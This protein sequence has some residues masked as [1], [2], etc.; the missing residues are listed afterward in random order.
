MYP[1][2]HIFQYAIPTF[3][4]L[5]LIGCGCGF[6]LAILTAKKYQITT[7]D[8]MFFGLFAMI[9]GIIGAKL[10]Y[11]IIDLPNLIASPE[12]ALMQLANGGA[13]FYGGLIGGI[14]GGFFYTHLYHLDAIKFFDIAVPSLALAQAFGRIG[15]FFN[16]CCYGIPYDGWGAVY[17]PIGAYPP[18]GIGLFPAQLTEST[19]LFILTPVLMIILM[20]NKTP[21]FTTGFYLVAAGIFRFINE[22]FR[23]DPRGTIGFLST[24][25]AISLFIIILGLL[26]LF[27]IPQMFYQKYLKH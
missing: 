22:F 9:G 23:S 19:F 26:F 1:L 17:Y 27:K 4:I 12:T 25:Q 16:G 15:C 11:I 3:G 13:V 8:A 6:L 14:L 10:L 20:K 5:F 21:G 18:A 24:S 7:M 2:I